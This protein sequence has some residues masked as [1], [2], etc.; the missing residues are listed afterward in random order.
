M[1]GQ[2]HVT[3]EEFEKIVLLPENQDKR[4][5]YIGGEVIEVVTNNYASE[6]AVNIV[7]AIAQHIEGKKV[8]FITGAN[9]GYKVFDDRYVPD[10]AFL[11][12]A[13]QPEPSREIFNSNAPD[14]AV[15]VMSPTDFPQDITIKVMNFLAAGTVVW[16]IYTDDQEAR[17]FESGKPV[18]VVT[19]NDELDG[20][21]VLPGFKLPL[22]DIF[23]D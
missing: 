2:S 4:L 3:V 9:G 21:N 18:K 11:S 7:V 1:V 16:V 23:K 20:G 15:E 22:K 5:E 8:G 12:R 6:I 14:L 19:I 13:R 10:V 17:M